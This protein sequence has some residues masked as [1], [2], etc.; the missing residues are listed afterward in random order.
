MKIDTLSATNSYK[1]NIHLLEFVHEIEFY[2][3][4]LHKKELQ[5]PSLMKHL[6]RQA[7]LLTIQ[8]LNNLTSIH[9]AEER[10]IQLVRNTYSPFHIQ[11]R[12]LAGHRDAL[13]YIHDHHIDYS[14]YDFRIVYIIHKEINQ[15]LTTDQLNEKTSLFPE[16]PLLPHSITST[17]QCLSTADLQKL[18]FEFQSSIEVQKMHPLIAIP[19]LLHKFF[20][21]IRGHYDALR[22]MRLLNIYLLHQFDYRIQCYFSLDRQFNESYNSFHD[23][24]LQR[25]KDQ[26]ADAIL[27]LHQWTQFYLETVLTAYKEIG[28]F[29]NAYKNR[30]ISEIKMEQIFTFITSQSEPFTKQQLLEHHP[31]AGK[32]LVEKMLRIL[33][34]KGQIRCIGKGKNIKWEW[35]SEKKNTI[36]S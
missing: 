17:S 29:I 7:N 15:H 30:S 16:N 33:R 34:N 4:H 6:Q 35:I 10:M 3:H 24:F 31:E 14:V 27:P 19:L 21:Q 25:F 11:E 36:M 22:L 32:Q 23:S 1:E 8:A 12:E 18:F 13:S 5:Y 2:D 28:G 20:K 26:D 9:L